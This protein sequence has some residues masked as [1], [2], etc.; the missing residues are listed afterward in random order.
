MYTGPASGEIAEFYF[1]LGIAGPGNGNKGASAWTGGSLQTTINPPSGF[2]GGLTSIQLAP[3]AIIDGE[4]SG[5]KFNDLDG[6]GV[7]DTNEEGLSGWTIFLDADADGT[8]DQGEVSTVTGVG[9]AYSFSV[10]PDADK[11]DIDNDPYVV[12]E[13]QQSGW[14]QTTVNPAPITITTADPTEANVNFGNRLFNP[15]LAILKDGVY[16]DVGADGLN[17]G[18]TLNY[19]FKVTN[20][21]D[22]TVTGVSINEVSFDLPGPIAVTAP[23]DVDLSPGEAATFTGVYTLTQADIDAIFL[24]STIDNVASATGLDPDTDAVTSNEDPAEITL[25][26]E[27]ALNIV[28]GTI[29]GGQ[30]GDNVSGVIAGRPIKWQYTVT[31]TGDVTLSN[32]TVKDNAG[33]SADTSDDFNATYVSG[34]HQR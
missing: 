5:V 2:G 34:D 26:P 13:V 20:T 9:G 29:Y 28:K 25:T 12:R 11:S 32:V 22:V 21:G 19:T 33:T 14:T 8:L 23:A 1:G 15:A 16:T 7:R 24:D 6:D 4:I 10:T 3:D 27:A 31:N 30:S 18:D 17:V